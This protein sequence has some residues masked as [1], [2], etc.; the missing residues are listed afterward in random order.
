MDG[1]MTSTAHV[2][3]DRPMRYGKQLAS[4]FSHKIEA[5][6]NKDSATG[7]AVFPIADTSDSVRC[8]MSADEGQLV[9]VLNGPAEHIGQFEEIVAR[10][11]LRFAKP[12]ELEVTF[13]RDNGESS[14]FV[15]E[16]E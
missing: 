2:T 5:S 6:W 13:V 16:E 15:Y 8:D 10:H 12:G 11:L 3:S 1:I 7:T 14:A 9:L 4:H